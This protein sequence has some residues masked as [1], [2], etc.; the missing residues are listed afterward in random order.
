MAR[1]VR[2]EGC[3]TL[4]VVQDGEALP[5]HGDCAVDMSDPSFVAGKIMADKEYAP[6]NI[7]TV[8]RAILAE[9]RA[10]RM[11]LEGFTKP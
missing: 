10:I 5:A 7:T 11:L 9:L 3:K 4:F 8:N 6:S 2:C 1:T